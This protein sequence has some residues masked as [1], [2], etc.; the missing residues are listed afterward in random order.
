MRRRKIG[1]SVLVLAAAAAG[2]G[3]SL[4]SEPVAASPVAA[5]VVVA[6]PSYAVADQVTGGSRGYLTTPQELKFVAARAAKGIEPY[7]S[8][9]RDAMKDAARPWMWT[10]P[11]S[12]STCPSAD[13][14]AYLREGG[15]I[16]YAKAVA[17]HL[18]GEVRFAREAQQ[19]IAGLSGFP[20]FGPPGKTRDPDRRCQLVLSWSVP[21][22][23]R[24]AD[25]LEDFPEWHASGA[26]ARFQ[27]WLA[28]VVYPTISFTA[29]VSVSNWGAAATNT[30][31]YIADYLWD[32]PELRLVSHNTAFADE[33][34]TT[35]TPG[36]AYEHAMQLALGRMSGVRAEGPGGSSSACDFDP[37]T[38]SMIRPDGGIPDELRRGSTGCKG[39]VIREDDHSNMYSQTHL[40]NVIAQA[41]LALRRGDRRLYDYE[42]ADAAAIEYQD[43]RGRTLR[44]TLPAGRG[45]LRRALLFVLGEPSR[46]RPRALG[47]AA[48]VA[49][50]YYR[51]PVL[52]SAIRAGRPHSGDRA[53][54]LETLTHAFSAGENPGPPPTVPPPGHTATVAGRREVA[55]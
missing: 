3:L 9:V 55:Q 32:R 25:L 46:Q 23:I 54:A 36:E 10:A 7:R 48:E 17:Y 6:P 41:E 22:F 51:D 35:R 1:V 19:A 40:Q 33:R 47:S 30:E 20:S 52:L 11:G 31:A 43:P 39:A 12:R 49:Y 38:K 14:P 8:A 28:A 15:P 5:L 18:S 16:A 37:A 50:R 53:M 27:E 26:K 45:S 2:L 34:T 4:R 13:E 21:H 29:E 44:A 24:A 42:A